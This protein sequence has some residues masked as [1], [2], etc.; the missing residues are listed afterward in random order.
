MMGTNRVHQKKSISAERKMTKGER[1]PGVIQRSAA[2]PPLPVCEETSRTLRMVG[3]IS[4]LTSA[5]L[6]VCTSSMLA[7]AVVGAGATAGLR[8]SEVQMSLYAMVR[9][10]RSATGQVTVVWR[11]TPAIVASMT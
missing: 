2:C 5:L 4:P 10:A 1:R 8:H 11:T 7:A 6:P 9:L 3:R